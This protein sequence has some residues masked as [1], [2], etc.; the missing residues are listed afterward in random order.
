MAREPPLETLP[1]ISNAL[2]L[3]ECV[4][5]WSRK[6]LNFYREQAANLNVG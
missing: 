2:A 5:F 1:K 6:K 4:H 3:S